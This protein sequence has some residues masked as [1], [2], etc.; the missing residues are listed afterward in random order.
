MQ[1]ATNVTGLTGIDRDTSPEMQQDGTYR[2][3]L[4]MRE[5]VSSMFQVD[6]MES[7]DLCVPLIGKIIG[8]IY[9]VDKFILFTTDNTVSEIG[10]F[11]PDKCKYEKI[12]IACDLNFSTDYPIQAAYKI[13]SICDDYTLYWTD[14]LNPVRVLELGAPNLDCNDI[15]LFSCKDLPTIK[16]ESVNDG[17][18][19][20]VCG[21]YQFAIRYRREGG[22][23]TSFFNITNPVPIY[24]EPYNSTPWRYVDGC[25]GGTPTSKSITL[26]FENLDSSYEYIDIVMI[27]FINGVPHHTILEGVVAVNGLHTVTNNGLIDIDILEVVV[28]LARWKYADLLTTQQNKLF[29]G[30]LQEIKNI[31]LQEVANNIKVE[32]FTIKV[33]IEKAYKDPMFYNYRTFIG[34][35][36]YALGLVVEYCDGYLSQSFHIPGPTEEDIT[37]FEWPLRS[38]LGVG[39][40]PV[41]EEELTD[42]E[43]NSL[44]DIVP[45]NDINNFFDCPKYVWEVYNTAG[46]CHELEEETIIEEDCG[47]TTGVT[48]GKWHQGHP[49]FSEE[50][51]VY[52][53][54][55]GCDNKPI[56]PH[57]ENPDG[58]FTMKNVRHHRMPSRRLEPHFSST[59]PL[60]TDCPQDSPNFPRRP[61]QEHFVYPIGL[62]VKNIDIPTDI[63]DIA[64]FKVV[65]VK[66]DDTNRSVI[67]K[68]VVH[69]TFLGYDDDVQDFYIFP[70]YVVNSLMPYSPLS[71]GSYVT[72]YEDTSV[73][74]F[75]SP[76]TSFNKGRNINGAY[77]AYEAELHGSSRSYGVEGENLLDEQCCAHRLNSNLINRS[78]VWE[79][80][81]N[82]T[83]KLPT[84]LSANTLLTGIYDAPFYNL[85]GES[86]VAFRLTHAMYP[87]RNWE[88]CGNLS[89]P[90]GDLSY[91][92]HEKNANSC[93]QNVE[94]CSRAF[95]G[96]FKRY[97]CR[98]YDQLTGLSYIEIGQ[99]RPNFGIVGP[100]SLEVFGD[101]FINYWAY[102]RSGDNSNYRT[103]NEFTTWN[104]LCYGPYNIHAEE[105]LKTP[106]YPWIGMIHTICESDINV[107]L[108]HEDDGES[109]FP[110]MKNGAQNLDVVIE[111]QGT[112][113][114]D[115]YL[116]WFH[117][118]VELDIFVN[119]GFDNQFTYNSDFSR[120]S[121]ERVYPAIPL[122]YNPCDCTETY[123]NSVAVSDPS[124]GALDGWRTFRVNN[125][126]DI[127][128]NTG[129]LRS[130]FSMSNNFYGHTDNNIWK[131]NSSESQIQASA[132]TVYLGSGDIFSA[133]PQYLY[134]VNEG[135]AGIQQSEGQLLNHLGYWFIDSV[136]ADIVNISES[137]QKIEK[138]LMEW[139]NENLRFNVKKY[140][141]DYELNPV[142]EVGWLI[143]FDY[144][145]YLV[146]ITKKDYEL[147]DPSL[148]KGVY[149]EGDCE[150]GSIYEHDGR[151]VVV[152]DVDCSYE[153]VEFTDEEYFCNASW[154]ISYS[155][156]R[157][158][159]KSWHS[160]IPDYYL[161]DRYNLF[162]SQGNNLYKHN[163]KNHYQTYYGTYYPA[164]IELTTKNKATAYWDNAS[165]ILDAYR[166][167]SIYKKELSVKEAFDYG[168]VYNRDQNSGMLNFEKATDYDSN[169]MGK[170]IKDSLT[171]VRIFRG[172]DMWNYNGFTDYVVDDT[173]PHNTCACLDVIDQIPNVDAI[174]TSKPYYNVSQF[175]G[176]Y[177]IQRLY[178]DN[179][180]NNTT[181]FNLTLLNNNITYVQR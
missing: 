160:F 144:K 116:S 107:D 159:F 35:E 156:I 140:L 43:Y 171:S 47:I 98:Q 9:L 19:N 91:I 6:N 62:I 33:P 105:A 142:G 65:M 102:H 166:Y 147:K 76:D 11:Y 31:E 73:Y 22:D 74:K 89:S 40:T 70:K 18:G 42:I 59:E 134:A 53:S 126:I 155:I 121:T 88:D 162:S 173:I 106:F 78:N 118:N 100:K 79:Y 152:I 172:N 32:W 113:W 157:K 94:Y 85:H 27:T 104:D 38:K 24:D 122:N 138:G 143:G 117:K 178:F 145:N 177:L 26:S 12:D 50:C 63:P 82:S 23:V 130:I 66:R 48:L 169:Y 68:G 131:I 41:V 7:N 49:A 114:A 81:Y 154:T 153:F 97:S 44:W 28:P 3:A 75:H 57:I 180:A 151:L 14:G 86:S 181:R 123:A 4:N 45:E 112:E 124:Y 148:F 132:A 168:Y 111:Q 99:T 108:R 21:I 51:E 179:I 84:Y 127:P 120:M 146:Y 37:C 83:V 36:K 55:L 170:A 58:T 129:R 8:S 87:F 150:L 125:I 96:A 71:G 17:G 39:D 163:I 34:D 25:E 135:F 15:T 95:Y 92:I 16:V 167:N 165:V 29:L 90:F 119:E 54:T 109:Y 10:Y 103:H 67:G 141:P 93:S 46:I 158:A 77:F 56:Y 64:G 139:L 133:V 161:F 61:W 80:Q 20:L 52:P 128:K 5:N 174:D 175:R 1:E 69:K 2:F 30:G 136:G 137:V 176:L 149:N 60:A 101:G 115:A 13:S 110:K 72:N 164:A